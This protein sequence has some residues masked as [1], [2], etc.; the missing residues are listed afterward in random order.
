MSAL[1]GAK[2]S[3]GAQHSPSSSGL[4]GWS[5]PS[6]LSRE[7]A[8]NESFKVAERIR[9]VG[10]SRFSIEAKVRQSSL[11]EFAGKVH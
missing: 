7:V 8:A 4:G 5:S 3:G 9:S 1:L 11:A 6:V 10:K 2:P